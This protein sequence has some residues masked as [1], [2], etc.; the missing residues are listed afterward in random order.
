M[1]ENSDDE[2]ETK[3]RIIQLNNELM[4]LLSSKP[5]IFS[6]YFKGF[7]GIKMDTENASN[8]LEPGLEKE[9]IR[10]KGGYLWDIGS[11]I[12]YDGSTTEVFS[13]MRVVN[14]MNYIPNMLAIMKINIDER[15]ISEIYS[16]EIS[17]DKDDYFIINNDSTIISSV[18]KEKL[19]SKLSSNIVNNIP[20]YTKEGHFQEMVDGKDCLVTYY[21]IQEMGYTIVN[22][23]P[24]NDLLKE[25][26]V[27]QLAMF[28]V[29]GVS[30]IVCVLF[31]FLFS[32]YV[33][34]PL[35]NIC[36]QMK[37]V[38]SEEFDVQVNLYGNDEIAMLGR[39]FN[40]M[41]LKLKELINQVYL[42]NIKQKEAELAALHAQINPH[43]LYNTLD[44]IYW[45]SRIEK[46][47]ETSKLI[48]AL[49]KLF[50]LSL[51]GGKDLILL[52]NE[53]EHLNNYLVIQK[54]RYGDAIKFSIDIEEDLLDCE[55]LKLVLQPLVE[56]AI[57]HGI[58]KKEGKGTINVVVKKNNKNIIY[59]IV[60][61]GIGIDIDEAY[62]LLKNIGDSNKGMGI[63]NVNDRLKLYFGDQYGLQFFRAEG[64]GTKVIVA[65]P[66]IKSPEPPDSVS[67]G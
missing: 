60:D 53:I 37:K 39:S 41:S 59:E 61:D 19:G 67:G 49:A 3:T 65:L 24:L 55:V 26:S 16:S 42:V 43:F 33:L 64:G 27:I 28:E 15:R 8:P 13:L 10:L 62:D 21:K 22:T 1:L 34:R 6:I 35:K 57:V 50:R 7:N 29:A 30:F 2:T 40:K 4:Y 38:E 17:E 51:N 66:C 52:K 36:I 45:V 12:N 44:T 23:V 14:D 9:I 47:F 63:K 5:Y 56:N 48:E 18:N 54:K 11:I 58:D 25:N 46:A 31:A 32:I 20:E